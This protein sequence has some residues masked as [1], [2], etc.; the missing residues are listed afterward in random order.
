MA[1]GH[2][3]YARQVGEAEDIL[4]ARCALC[5]VA[6]TQEVDDFYAE[7]CKACA[8]SALK[9]RH[10][11]SRRG[12]RR[13]SSSFSNSGTVSDGLRISRRPKQ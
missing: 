6:L 13:T 8:L 11:R 9:G 12:Q 3:V 4:Q 1:E 2:F 7:L 5:R 10:V